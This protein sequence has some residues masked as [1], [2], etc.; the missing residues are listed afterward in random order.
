MEWYEWITARVGWNIA[1]CAMLL[2]R[3][4]WLAGIASMEQR[5][6]KLDGVRYLT[7]LNLVFAPRRSIL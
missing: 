7:V 5:N 6:T 1:C 3:A 2:L 4:D